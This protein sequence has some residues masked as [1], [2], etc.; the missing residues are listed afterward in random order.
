MNTKVMF[1][2]AA[3]LLLAIQVSASIPAGAEKSGQTPQGYMMMGRNVVVLPEM[4]HAGDRMDLFNAVGEK[5]LEAYVGHGYMAANISNLP[6]GAYTL[7]I[8]RRGRIITSQMTPF[9]GMGAR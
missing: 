6:Q 7:V 1:A 9:I 5:V 2:M 4:L 8:S 3:G